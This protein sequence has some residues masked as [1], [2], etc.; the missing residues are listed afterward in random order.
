MSITLPPAPP[1]PPDLAPDE[2]E[3]LIKEARRRARRRRALYGIAALLAAGAAVAAFE[4][5]GGGGGQAE[6]A[7][8]GGP[9]APGAPLLSRP[10]PAPRPAKNGPLA[11]IVGAYGNGIV[12]VGP[13]GRFLRSLP[14]CHA[15]QCGALTTVAWSPDGNT[16][17]YGTS[18]GGNSHPREGL[19]IFDVARNK[20]RLFVDHS[21]NWGDLAWSPD[22]TKL[23]YVSG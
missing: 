5:F 19:H 21:H 9:D 18:W 11:V 16:L 7:A 10:G 1:R 14:I 23:A 15:P 12:M 6:T 13:R 17:A 20:D 4:G 2:L 8:P 22:G 3:A